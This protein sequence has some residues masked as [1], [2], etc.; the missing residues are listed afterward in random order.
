MHLILLSL[1]HGLKAGSTCAACTKMPMIKI[2]GSVFGCLMGFLLTTIALL[3][4]ELSTS[5]PRFNIAASL[6]GMYSRVEG[7][8]PVR[9][10]IVRSVYFD[11][12][13]RSNH[14]NSS[15]FMLE[16]KESIV[17]QK[18]IVGCGAGEQV[19]QQLDVRLCGVYEWI[20]EK[21]P[22]L[23]HYE[24]MIDCFDLSA[25]NGSD[26]FIVYKPNVASPETAIY[27]EHQIMM[28]AELPQL[29]TQSYPFTIISCVHVFDHPP[30]FNEWL[31]YQRAIGIDHV[32][33]IA[34]RSF[35]RAGGFQ[36]VYLKQAIEN[37]YV[38]IDVWEDWLNLS[39]VYYHS[40]TLAYEDCVYRFRG[41][42]DYALM[43]DTDDFFIPRV[44]GQKD[45]HY[46]VKYWCKHSGSCKFPWIEYYPDCGLKHKVDVNGN[47][48]DALSSSMKSTQ[49]VRKS[50]HKLSAIVDTGVHHAWKL[51]KGYVTRVVPAEK[52]YIAHVRK[53]K[54]HKEGLC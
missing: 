44:P 42:Y 12:R 53:G 13:R 17:D 22:N 43:V 3:I 51:M 28:P 27:S 34:D 48:T 21:F 1:L 41:T 23:T 45:L 6:V 19:T 31:Q 54:M 5:V 39:E 9:D 36:N 33:I 26:A 32:H 11:D 16:V 24:V 2:F 35:D 7:S 18:L 46:Y 50:L 4:T 14:D 47:V 25:D 30:W 20:N 40:Q 29:S 38:S 15:V 8:P 52:A 10:V 37:G 49:K